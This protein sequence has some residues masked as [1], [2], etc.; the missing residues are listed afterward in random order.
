MLKLTKALNRD[1]E[2]GF[3]IVKFAC[4]LPLAGS[5]QNT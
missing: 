5:I 3:I 2:F 4:Y 1:T